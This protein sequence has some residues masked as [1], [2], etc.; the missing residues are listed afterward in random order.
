MGHE[1][2]VKKYQALIKVPGFYN[3]ELD[4]KLIILIH[5]RIV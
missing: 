3:Y 4:F 5:I 1:E 2:E